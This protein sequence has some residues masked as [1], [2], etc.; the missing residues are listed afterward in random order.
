MEPI[1]LLLLI[2]LALIA[3]LGSLTQIFP[4]I[5]LLVVG[6]LMWAIYYGGSTW[7]FFLGVALI[8]GIALAIKYIIPARYLKR[9]GIPKRTLFLGAVAGIIGFFIIPIIGLPL[10]FILGVF[11]VEYST[12]RTT[13]W[14][15]TRTA[16]KGIAA[17][18]LIELIATAAASG[19]LIIGYFA[20]HN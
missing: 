1:T 7:W 5:G 11:L 14:E 19:L 4:G 6:A 10:G 17:S 8:T 12:D 20:L 2:L 3:M 13:A 15:K 16:V 18:M 9:E